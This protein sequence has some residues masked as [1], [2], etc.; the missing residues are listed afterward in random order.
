MYVVHGVGPPVRNLKLNNPDID[1]LACALL[2]RMYYCKVDGVF[3]E[4]PLPNSGTVFKRLAQFRGRLIATFGYS[5]SRISPE[6]FAEMYTGRKRTIYENAVEEYTRYGVSRLDARSNPFVKCEKVKPSGAP[7]CIQPRKPVYNV[8]LGTFIKHIEHTIY[9]SIQRV[10]RSDTP[11]VMKGLNVDDIASAIVDKWNCFSNPVAVGLDATKFDMHV[12]EPMLRWEHSIY[13]KLYNG[14][15]DLKTLLKWQRSSKG[16]GYCADGSLKYSVKG[17]R[18][19]GDMNTGLGNC[20]IMCGLIY[21]Y[22]KERGIGIQLANNGDDCVVFLEQRELPAFSLGLDE[23]FIQ[24]G[25]RMT[26]EK[27]VYNIEEIEFCQMHPIN[28]G[29]SWRMVR[30]FDTSREKDSIC[31]F[32]ISNNQAYRKWL[33]AVGECGLALTGGVPVMQS[34]YGAYGRAGVSS[35]ILKSVQMQSGFL[36]LSKGMKAKLAVVSSEARFSF[37]VAFGITPDEQVALEEYYDTL[38]ITEN[39]VNIVEQLDE[40]ISAPM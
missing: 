16:S 11:V 25:F 2:E 5:P 8:A 21:A 31:L 6:Q 29:E 15:S 3:V 39:D 28:L 36:M 24:M 33:G 30:N 19:S 9:H 32:D 17:R 23:W 38:N 1:T 35:D 37:F 14:N 4:P 34:M 27:P 7:R 18:F 12:S 22:A 40:I 26:V 20:I 10:Y 13:E